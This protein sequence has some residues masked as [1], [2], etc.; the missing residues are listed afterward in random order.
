MIINFLSNKKALLIL[1]RACCHEYSLNRSNIIQNFHGEHT[2]GS[3]QNVY[4]VPG[5]QYESNN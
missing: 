5:E 2:S 4:K 3:T 1:D